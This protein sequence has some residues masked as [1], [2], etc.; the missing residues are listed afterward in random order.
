VTLDV[1]AKQRKCAQISDTSYFKA[2]I[3]L[4]EFLMNQKKLI[5]QFLTINRLI[6][7]YFSR[8]PSSSFSSAQR[9]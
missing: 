9:S 8:A 2:A 1:L 3:I 6:N 7:R 5:E 4:V